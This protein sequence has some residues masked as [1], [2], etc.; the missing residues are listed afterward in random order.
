QRRLPDKTGARRELGAEAG[1][2][3]NTTAVKKLVAA[4]LPFGLGLGGDT[5]YVL[6]EAGVTRRRHAG[7]QIHLT[8]D[9][10]VVDL[11]AF[12]TG[13]QRELRTRIEKLQVGVL[14]RHFRAIT[15]LD[16]LLVLFGE[17]DDRQAQEITLAVIIAP[18]VI[19]PTPVPAGSESPI[20]PTFQHPQMRIAGGDVAI[21]DIVSKGA[22]T[23]KL[24]GVSLIGENFELVAEPAAA[25]FPAH[26]AGGI[27]IALFAR[28]RLHAAAQRIAV[29]VVLVALMCGANSELHG[30]IV[31]HEF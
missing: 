19:F 18:I 20:E 6:L 27:A 10:V 5:V 29:A 31:T 14:H 30:L 9:I 2:I 23:G 24:C 21:V 16:D 12:G 7:N 15:M 1:V 8:G 28:S 11:L 13:V 4:V 22:G 25:T 26:H 17:I 3:V